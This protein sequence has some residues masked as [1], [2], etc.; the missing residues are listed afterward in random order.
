VTDT[1]TFD[2]ANDLARKIR[3]YWSGR[4]VKV[5][6]SEMSVSERV[7]HETRIWCVRS[8]LLNGLPVEPQ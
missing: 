4:G 7:Q 5:W 6:V 1:L 3:E 8:N 2:G